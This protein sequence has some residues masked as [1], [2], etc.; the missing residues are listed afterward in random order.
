MINLT[1][2]R[3]CDGEEKIFLQVSRLLGLS[4]FF[5]V[6]FQNNLLG[7]MRPIVL[8]LYAQTCEFCNQIFLYI[9][10]YKQYFQMFCGAVQ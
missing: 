9:Q 10:M 6:K 7:F 5:L 1:K 2:S 3:F 4:D 8:V